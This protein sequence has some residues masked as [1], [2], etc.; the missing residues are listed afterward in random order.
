MIAGNFKSDNHSRSQTDVR[1]PGSFSVNLFS[2][3]SA[4]LGLGVVET[5]ELSE[6]APPGSHFIVYGFM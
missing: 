2:V 1:F 5:Y 3:H 6:C 4:W